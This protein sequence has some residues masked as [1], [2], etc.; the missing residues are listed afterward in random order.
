[1]YDGK[2]KQTFPNLNNILESEAVIFDI[3]NYHLGLEDDV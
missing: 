2:D 3:I 1:M